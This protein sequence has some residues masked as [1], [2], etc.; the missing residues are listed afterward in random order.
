MRQRIRSGDP[1]SAIARG[2]RLMSTDDNSRNATSSGSR[3][4]IAW[5]VGAAVVLIG[6]LVAILI[7][8]LPRGA[9]DAGATPS[10]TSSAV[11]SSTSSP[12]AS[13]SAT[14]QPS[15]EP[16]ADADDPF[17]ELAPVAPEEPGEAE[18]IGARLVR[19]ES[20]TG[21]V[22]GP[23]DV[24]AAA[25]RVTVDITNTGNVPLNLDLVVMNAYMGV[26]RDPAE[27]YEQPGGSPVSGE[28]APGSTATGVYLFRI[29]ED[30]RDDVTFVVDYRAG[31]PA[32]T[33]RGP[34]PTS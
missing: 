25:V 10:P 29:P 34:V 17:P 11:P 2:E 7:A 6:V 19:F 9:A 30:R 21:E 23:G 32:I 20:V 12:G 26:Q 14:D 33:F 28:L 1:L 3:A 13:G 31:L 8:V 5:I 18:G 15:A 24:E 16:T 27:T 22:V 4:R